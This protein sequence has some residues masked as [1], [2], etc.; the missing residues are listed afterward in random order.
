[1]LNSPPAMKY[2]EYNSHMVG[3]SLYLMLVC[4]VRPTENT[5][6]GGSFC[7]DT[8]NHGAL[9]S[10]NFTYSHEKMSPIKKIYIYIC[11]NDI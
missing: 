6:F 4:W 11:G 10:G 2:K 3:V 7:S 8:P 5:F 9:P 1:M